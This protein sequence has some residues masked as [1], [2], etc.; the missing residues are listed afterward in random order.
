MEK[1]ESCGT[2]C[3]SQREMF[4]GQ[5]SYPLH[6]AYNIEN[7]FSS[8]L[9]DK[10]NPRHFPTLNEVAEHS[11]QVPMF[12]SALFFNY[13][14]LDARFFARVKAT[15]EGFILAFWLKYVLF[16]WQ[17]GWLKTRFCLF[18]KN[19]VVRFFFTTCP[20]RIH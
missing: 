13:L 2:H 5:A 17:Q 15:T 1:V 12:N 10:K 20:L 8:F 16:P 14:R 11:F 6:P 19:S 7:H 4:R 18:L 9:A 3:H